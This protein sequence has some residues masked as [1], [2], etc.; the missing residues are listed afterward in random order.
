MT[1][2]VRCLSFHARYRC[3]H[4]G[5]CCTAGWP[6]PIETDALA[7][8]RAHFSDA[9]MRIA[10]HVTLLPVTYRGCAFHDA[11]AHR[12]TIHL[13][14]DHDALPLACRQFPRVIVHDPRGVSVALSCY[15]PTARGLLDTASPIAIVDDA[16]AFPRECEYVG[17]DARTAL[18]PALC[19]D[20]LMDWD[21]WWEWER[22]SVDL[23]NLDEPLRDILARLTVAVEH[24]R[25]WRPGQGELLDRVRE[26]QTL[27]RSTARTHIPD[28][29]NPPE[30]G[31]Q[32]PAHDTNLTNPPN[33]RVFMSCHCFSNWTA[34]LGSGLRTWL[35]SI[36]TVVFLLEIGWSIAEIDL[37][38]RHWAD[39]HQLARVWSAAETERART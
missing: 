16:P 39:P 38:L 6:I 20:V 19:P 31:E 14:L 34:H 18:P 22:L 32:N 8:V 29:T 33:L 36:E 10:G 5:E 28:P 26:A 12:C 25:T 3:A 17:L 27:A 9:T 24:A 23:W 35:R 7:R 30:P 1:G 37:W 21:S 13:A 15:C 11:A 2:A 4:S